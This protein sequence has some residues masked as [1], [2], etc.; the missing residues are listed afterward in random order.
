[1]KKLIPLCIWAFLFCNSCALKKSKTTKCFQGQIGK[2]M[3]DEKKTI[4]QSGTLGGYDTLKYFRI[5]FRNDSTF[6]MNMV[7][8]FFSDTIGIWDPGSCGF[9]SSGSIR[10][11]HSKEVQQFGVCQENDSF[12]TKMSPFKAKHGTITLWFKKIK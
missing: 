11:H 5:E 6:Q 2:Y 3:F 9:E 7:V 8:D 10:Y 4:E 12:F 1:M